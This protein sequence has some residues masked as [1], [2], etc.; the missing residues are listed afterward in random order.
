MN[1]EQF[2]D[3]LYDPEIQ[4]HLLREDPETFNYAITQAQNLDAINR[5]S[6]TM[7]KRRIAYVRSMQEKPN[8]RRDDPT[9]FMMAH[10]LHVGMLTATSPT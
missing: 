2:S 4:E 6:T 8:T 9:A 7:H 3:G 1:R 10:G 5:T